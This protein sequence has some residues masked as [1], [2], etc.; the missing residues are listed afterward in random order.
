[1]EETQ[2]WGECISGSFTLGSSGPS[3]CDRV[4][5]KNWSFRSGSFLVPPCRPPSQSRSV[6]PPQLLDSQRPQESRC[7]IGREP[8]PGPP[9]AL[10]SRALWAGEGPRERRP[11]GPTQQEG[12]TLPKL[13]A[14][15]ASLLLCCAPPA[16]ASIALPADG[17]HRAG[18][19]GALGRRKNDSAILRYVHIRL[20]LDLCNRATRL[21]KR[22]LRSENDSSKSYYL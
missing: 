2:S 9:A 5:G 6:A 11:H 12:F 13:T 20:P 8:S 18:V 14:L 15:W 22:K 19:G 1:M 16:P 17:V 21:W 7:D 10:G 4:H 3:N